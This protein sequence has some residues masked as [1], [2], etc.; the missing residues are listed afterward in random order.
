MSSLLPAALP[1]ALLSALHLVGFAMG[2]YGIGLRARALGRG[3]L[4]T[5]L[6]ADNIWGIAAL[7]LIPSG[8]VRAFGGLEK[9][10]DFYLHSPAFWLKMGLLALL[11]A[12]ELWPMVLLIRWRI[13][14]ARVETRLL[15]RLA[16]ISR[17]EVGLLLLLPVAAAM[18]ARG[19]LR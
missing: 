10:A 18:M 8:L 15:P 19:V 11:M 2:L 7:I 9:G 1:A 6:H 16:W 4:P 3:D 17:L 14:P 12:L 5:A 13:R